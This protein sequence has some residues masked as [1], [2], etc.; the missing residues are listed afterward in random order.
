MCDTNTEKCVASTST[1]GSTTYWVWVVDPGCGAQQHGFVADSQADAQTA[2]Q[3][4]FT[5]SFPQNAG[6][7][8][9]AVSTGEY[10]TAP[11][12]YQVCPTDCAAV[13]GLMETTNTLYAF[14]PG[15][16]PACELYLDH[17]CNW[18]ASACA[19]D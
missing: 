2:A 12:T 15:K 14:D 18:V 4:W 7:Y 10:A 8:L 13:G 5:S 1:G 3:T 6:Y 16:I 9:G 19:G 17:T 11:M